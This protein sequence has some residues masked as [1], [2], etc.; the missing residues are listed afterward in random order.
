MRFSRDRP[1]VGLVRR[2][3]RSEPPSQGNWLRSRVFRHRRIKAGF[4]G[5]R[6]DRIHRE[7]RKSRD[8]CGLIHHDYTTS[9]GDPRAFTPRPRRADGRRTGLCFGSMIAGRASR[10][11]PGSNLPNLATHLAMHFRRTRWEVGEKALIDRFNLFYLTGAHGQLEPT[12]CDSEVRG[13]NSD[14]LCRETV[15]K[16]DDALKLTRRVCRIVNPILLRIHNPRRN[17]RM[18]LLLS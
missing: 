16:P 1:R 6:F 11:S 2:P 12:F 8:E 15:A 17:F 18:N 3:S 14:P 10:R 9:S 4:G 5:G 13:N 7:L